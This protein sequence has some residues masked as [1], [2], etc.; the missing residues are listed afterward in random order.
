MSSK[1]DL[2]RHLT[3]LRHVPPE[4]VIIFLQDTLDVLFEI[5]M[6]VAKDTEGNNL[7]FEALVS[8]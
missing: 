3:D 8:H 5:L 6:N 2:R 1:T 7:V 4:E